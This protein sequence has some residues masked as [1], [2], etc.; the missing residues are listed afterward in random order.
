MTIEVVI[1]PVANAP[2]PTIL[3]GFT[4]STF[5]QAVYLSVDEDPLQCVEM[6]NQ[7]AQKFIDACGEAV[8]GWKAANAIP[9]T[10]QSH[11]A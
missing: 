4:D 3:M 2:R 8:K 10:F 9:D 6:A 11:D 1:S 7:I 5:S